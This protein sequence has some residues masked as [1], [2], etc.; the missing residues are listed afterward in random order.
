MSGHPLK[1]AGRRP[2]VVYT[3]QYWARWAVTRFGIHRLWM[4]GS[5]ILDPGCGEG[6]LLLSLIMEALRDGYSPT[7]GDLKRLRGVDVDSAALDVFRHTL[8]GILGREAPQDIAVQDD[9]LLNDPAFPSEII[10]SN[11]PWLSFGDL[12][13]T[14]KTEYKPLF[15]NS[16]LVDKARELLLGGSRIDLSALFISTGLQRD[17][18]NGGIGYF[19]LPMSLFRSEGAH[20]GFRSRL[21]SPESG[22][23]LNE[24][25]ELGDGRP[26]PGAGTKAGFAEIRRNA[27][28]IWPVKWYRATGSDRW[29]RMEA[30]P[31][32]GIGSPLIPLEKGEPLPELPVIPVPPGTRPRQGA[33]PCGAA[34]VFVFDSAEEIDGT[35]LLM[36][37]RD[38]QSTPL[39]SELIHPL[40]T[41][42]NF[43]DRSFRERQKPRRW[44]F[45]PY[46]SSGEPMDPDELRKFPEALN[47]L[48]KHRDALEGR[49]GT[50]LQ[51]RMNQGFLWAM[52]GVGAYAFAPWKLVWEAY[53]QSE[54]RPGLFHCPPH[55]N[56]QGNQALHAYLPFWQE[57]DARRTLSILESGETERYLRS[58]G[59]ADT[60][61]WAQPSRIRRLLQETDQ[62]R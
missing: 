20:R 3:P 21:F 50:L 46:L 41:G 45:L 43:R 19:F 47:W 53:G 54:F 23:A 35:T 25:R 27:S 13:D 33:N 36:T 30:R 60:K 8:T 1:K 31:V 17:L 61:N 28:Q 55:R 42:R 16:G 29:H 59:G 26:F 51:R 48:E 9:Y 15:R 58:L 18:K 5:R 34:S 57:E 4:E 38:G 56:W 32:N 37:N 52:M 62:N 6:S 22:F 40:L 44:I 39:P 49:R 10:L 7:D 14:K 11:P 24:V 12:E 2:G